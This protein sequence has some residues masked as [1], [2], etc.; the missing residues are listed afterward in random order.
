MKKTLPI[1]TLTLLLS[2]SWALAQTAS[3]A[4]DD[5]TNSGTLT[6]LNGAPNMGT[7]ASGT[8][9]FTFDVNLTTAGGTTHGFSL[10]LETEAPDPK[11]TITGNTHFVFALTTD[12]E[13]FPWHFTDSSGADGAGFLTDQSGTQAGDLGATTSGADVAVGTNK[14]LTV[15]FTLSGLAPGTYH[16]DTTTAN[17]KPSE[18]TVAGGDAFASKA[19]YTFTINPVPEPQVWSLVGLGGLGSFGLTWL[20]ARKRS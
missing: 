16:I 14:V 15:Q 11:I 12:G 4:F 1:V 19:I 7:F 8:G 9:T 17:P 20:R 3:F 6:D 2:A 13:A 10:W 5:S 18:A